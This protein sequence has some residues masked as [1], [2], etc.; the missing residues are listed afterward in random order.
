MDKILNKPINKFC[1]CCGKE[2]AYKDRNKAQGIWS[3]KSCK[4]SYLLIVTTQ[5]KI[6]IDGTEQ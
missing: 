5:P 2:T 1:P 4:A 3:C 6:T